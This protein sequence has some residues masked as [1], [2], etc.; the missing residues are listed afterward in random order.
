MRNK[1]ILGA[2]A[3]TL[4]VLGVAAGVALAGGGKAASPSRLDDGTDLL[5]QAKITEQQAIDA[6]QA[7]GPGALNE[8]D[9]E[10]YNG[11]L[12]YNVDVGDRDVKV[13]ADSGD[14][15]ASDKDD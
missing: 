14:V 8:V 13:D 1:K 6:A 3:A 15:L 10:H 2:A 5:S 7:S 12:V 9:L 4:A 11:K